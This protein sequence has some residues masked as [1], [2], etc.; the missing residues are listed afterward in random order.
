MSLVFPQIDRKYLPP[1]PPISRFKVQNVT[2]LINALPNELKMKIY[3]EYLEP[4]IYYFMYQD[5]IKSI[6][7]TK[8]NMVNLRPI[9]PILLSKPLVRQFICKKCNTFRS[10]FNKH[11]IEKDKL[12]TK[13]IKG[14]SF[15]LSILFSIYH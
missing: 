9:I 1:F 4:E 12:F 7:S 14:D 10:V 3:K 5:A 15:A 13:L 2:N 8:L 11:K 6:E